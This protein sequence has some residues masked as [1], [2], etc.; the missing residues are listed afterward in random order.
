MSKAVEQSGYSI[1]SKDLSAII[2]ALNVDN[3]K[4]YQFYNTEISPN[5]NA[6]FKY[7]SKFRS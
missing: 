4:F 2:E 3:L 6:Y 1:H 7:Q 5:E